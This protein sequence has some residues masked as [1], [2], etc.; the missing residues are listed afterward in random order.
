[1]VTIRE[2]S[3]ALL[4]EY[5]RISIAFQA[6]SRFRVEFPQSGAAV[7]TLVEEGVAPFTKDYDAL[8]GEGPASWARRWDLS[9]WGILGAFDGELRVGGAAIAW[10]TP[11]LDLLQGDDRQAVLWDLRVHPDHRGQGV[12]PRLFEHA[13]NWAQQRGCRRL[14]VETQNINVAACRFYQRQ[15]CTL[16]GAVPFAYPELPEEVQLL[17]IRELEGL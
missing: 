6:A 17:W 16:L 13:V 11:A 8:P 15:G 5:G 1:M 12:G 3:P 14:L 2:Q 9:H 7:P 4:A 10:R